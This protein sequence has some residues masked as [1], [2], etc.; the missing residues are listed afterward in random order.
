MCSCTRAESVH[1]FCKEFK[2]TILDDRSIGIK[3]HDLTNFV[4][5]TSAWCGI[6]G[7]MSVPVKNATSKQTVVMIKKIEV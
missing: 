6:S 4:E 5:K 1:S 7:K 3:Q 2:W